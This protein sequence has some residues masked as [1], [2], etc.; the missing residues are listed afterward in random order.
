MAQPERKVYTDNGSAA[1]DLYARQ[2]NAARQYETARLREQP[3][4]YELPEELPQQ[5]PYR[6]V[7]A[8][9]AIA[10]FT[11]VGI[12]S[13]ACLMVL[14]IFGYVQLFEASSDVSRLETKLANL[15]EQQRMLQSKYDA[16][17]DLDAAEQYA[18]QVGLSKC[19]PEQIVYVSF[20]GTDQAE[21]YRQTRSS[22]FAEI[23]DA[24][25]QSVLGLIEYLHPAAA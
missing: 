11:L 3:R 22:L 4:Q 21:I 8:R 9:T 6:R 15:T 14:V 16:K 1:Y 18:Q 17:I 5:Q 10:P 12:L 25:Q 19:Q 23:V 2:S 13:V 20:S 24:M 7:K